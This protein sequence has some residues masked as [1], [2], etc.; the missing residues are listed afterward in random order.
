[1]K[2][3]QS[4]LNSPERRLSPEE[5]RNLKGGSATCRCTYWDNNGEAAA[6]TQGQVSGMDCYSA[7]AELSYVYDGIWSGVTCVPA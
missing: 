3:L 2:T 5:M 1:M 7:G 6:T 4:I